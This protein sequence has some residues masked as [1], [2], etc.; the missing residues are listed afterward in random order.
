[1]NNKKFIFYHWTFCKI[2]TSIL[3][4]FICYFQKRVFLFAYLQ[5]CKPLAF[6]WNSRDSRASVQKCNDC[7]CI[8]WVTFN[9][10]VYGTFLSSHCIYLVSTRE[11]SCIY[12]GRFSKEVGI[13]WPFY[14]MLKC[15]QAVRI[16]FWVMGSSSNAYAHRCQT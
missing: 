5:P 6:I 4:I 13:L 16:F 14:K 12:N 7:L 10:T 2:K 9:T 8:S 11:M 15:F 3:N 1:M